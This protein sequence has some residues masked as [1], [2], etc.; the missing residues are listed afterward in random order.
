M[1][2]RTKFLL[3]TLILSFGVCAQEAAFDTTREL[4]LEEEQASETYIHQGIAREKNQELC[5]GEGKFKDICTED[6]FA[7]SGGAFRTIEAMLP[8]V[9]RAY[10]MIMAVGGGT[11]KGPAK[12]A[13]GNPIYRVQRTAE[14]GTVSEVD[15]AIPEG[16]NVPEGAEQQKEDKPDYCR[17]I[18]MAGEAINIAMAQS[19]NQVTQRNLE[20]SKP[21][22]RQ[23][24]SFYA[25]AKNHKDQAK[26]SKLQMG[27]WGATAG[28]YAALLATST[29]SGDTGV[30]LKLGGSTLIAFFYMKKA[31]AHKERAKLLEQMAKELPQAGDCNPFTATTCFCNED[32]SFASDPSNFNKFCVP[33]PLVARNENNDA[34]FCVDKDRKVDKNCDCASQGTCIDRVLKGGGLDF[35]IN[36]IALKNP[37][38]GLAPLSNGRG[39]GTL[40]AVTGRNLNAAK[41]ALKKFQPAKVELSNK[42]KKIASDFNKF[43][44]P[45]GISAVLARKTSGIKAAALPSAFANNAPSA[46][47]D[48]EESSS[49]TNIAKVSGYQSGNEIKSGKKS[50]NSNPFARFKKKRKSNKGG[51]G[52]EIE[53]YAQKAQREAEIIKNTDI[54]IFSVISNRYQVS[55]WRQFPTAF[56]VE[57]AKEVKE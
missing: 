45:K 5:N 10:S 7:F 19:D 9:T 22:A 41:K 14:D 24:A 33:K 29:I 54:S 1:N 38:A 47:L 48:A 15:Q 35:G 50:N 11:L 2:K 43:G 28:C 40:D 34:S 55:A 56:E 44:L 27:V 42:Q 32:T 53:D 4:T 26:A 46:I 21:E 25:L 18:P 31:K 37:L 57:D 49:G 39:I 16:E 13:D 52:I 17:F 3:L 23:A 6:R 8:V 20:N 36:P 51:P 12:D 30:Y